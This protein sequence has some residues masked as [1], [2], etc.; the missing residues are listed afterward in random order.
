LT[1]LSAL[2]WML[3]GEFSSA[4]KF[5]ELALKADPNTEFVRGH[6][7][8]AY[9]ELGDVAAA[10]RLTSSGADP[11]ATRATAVDLRNGAIARAAA[12]VRAFP[13]R[14]VPCDYVSH[15]YAILEDAVRTRDF[16]GARQFLEKVV[17]IDLR[18]EPH[19]RAGSE[20]SAT[21]VAQLLALGG[22]D[23]RARALLTKVLAQTQDYGGSML[24]RC[25]NANRTRARALALLGRNTEAVQHLSRAVLQENAW[26]YGWYLFERDSAFA[27]LRGSAGFESLHAAYRNRV[28]AE[29]AKLALLRDDGLIPARP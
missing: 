21:I 27:G 4:V 10:D 7:A 15:S 8:D 23:A 12:K 1:R 3:H 16:T 18:D 22:D 19:V 26:Y 5:G 9:L 11:S 6:L 2:Y 20:F 28:T 13:E 14:F 24:P 25:G 29:K 17:E